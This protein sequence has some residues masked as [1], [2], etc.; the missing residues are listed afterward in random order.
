MTAIARE[1][2]TIS[3]YGVQLRVAVNVAG[4]RVSRGV[5]LPFPWRLK[6]NGEHHWEL[7]FGYSA[8]RLTRIFRRHFDVERRGF[9]TENPYHYLWC[10]RRRAALVPAAEA[11]R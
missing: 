1:H 8:R 2:L 3:A 5:S 7:G 9:V 11:G 10:M 6:F 4:V